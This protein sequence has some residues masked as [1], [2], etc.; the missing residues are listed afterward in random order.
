MNK[1]LP[2][3]Q[4]RAPEYLLAID[5]VGVSGVDFPLTLRKKVGGEVIVDS[6]FNMFGS[7]IKEKK[8]VDMSRFVQTL[9]TWTDIPLSG[10]NLEKLVKELKENIGS[11]D[12]YVSSEFK[13]YLNRLSPIT[14]LKMVRAYKCKFVGIFKNKYKFFQEVSVPIT[15]LCPCSKELSLVDKKKGI[16]KGAH[17]QKG[18]I[19]LQ[20]R[21]SP[22][23]IWLEDL[24][25]VCESS[26][27]SIIYPL[28]KRP[29]EKFVTEVAYSNPRFTEDIARLVSTKVM[30]LKGIIWFRVK[31]ENHESI[32]DHYATCYME[33]TKME[34]KWKPSYKGLI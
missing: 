9:M 13:Y 30:D 24:I 6:I 7:L 2:D 17:N 31:V 19:T 12:A 22:D 18:I 8:G 14:K 3:V 1:E 27:S 11:T 33:R 26:G 21:C 25:E 34:L 20:V 32:H 23:S 28:L 15:S 4:K 5:R 16:G 29:D 10:P